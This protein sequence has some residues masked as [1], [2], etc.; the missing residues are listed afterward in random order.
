MDKKP[1]ASLSL[2]L[3]KSQSWHKKSGYVRMFSGCSKQALQLQI[4]HTYCEHFFLFPAVAAV[5][6]PRIICFY[7][8]WHYLL[9]IP[10][11]RRVKGYARLVGKYVTGRRKRFRPRKVYIF[12]IRITSQVGLAMSVCPYE[13]WDLGNYKS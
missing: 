9:F 5:T 8:P 10:V 3:A 12:L 6:L 2:L 13:R 4:F 1:I 7:T 11:T